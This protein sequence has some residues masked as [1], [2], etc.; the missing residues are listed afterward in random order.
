ME[1]AI[2]SADSKGRVTLPGFANAT[3][4]VDMVSDTEYRIRKARVIPE[5]DL[6]FP[7]EE[8]PLKLTERETQQILDLLDNPPKPT[9]AARRA[10]KRFR[11]NYG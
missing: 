3:V 10:A 9:A 4:I 11:K 6:R 7:E 1:T 2:R 8:M 5:S